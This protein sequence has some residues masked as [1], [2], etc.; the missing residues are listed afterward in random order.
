[1]KFAF[2]LSLFL[3]H[4]KLGKSEFAKP[5]GMKD[6]SYIEWTTKKGLPR[7]VKI[8]P[9]P[10][11]IYPQI[12]TWKGKKEP[13]QNGH[14]INPNYLQVPLFP[15]GQDFPIFVYSP[16]GVK[17]LWDLLVTTSPETNTI[18][19][20]IDTLN[21][22]EHLQ[23]EICSKT[24][25]TSTLTLPQTCHSFNANLHPELPVTT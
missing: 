7:K 19:T 24:V 15:K 6:N 21:A 12:E 8:T 18:T 20:R 22:T 2:A 11:T 5:T 3:K 25:T 13:N 9:N 1:M 10:S 4:M 23:R 17:A 14:K 16:D